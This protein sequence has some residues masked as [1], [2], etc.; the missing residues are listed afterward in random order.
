MAGA[1]PPAEQPPP[2]TTLYGSI[3]NGGGTE[4]PELLAKLKERSNSRD[5]SNFGASF[6]EHAREARRSTGGGSAMA[7]DDDDEE[8]EQID[9]AALI[10][11]SDDDA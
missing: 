4:H 8:E 3:G 11:S 5:L 2:E 1:P 9:Y 10:D 7:K 6:M